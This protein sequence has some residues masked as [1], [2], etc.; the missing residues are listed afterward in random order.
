VL[1][2]EARR[3]LVTEHEE[4]TYCA[5]RY[6]FQVVGTRLPATSSD[7]QPSAQQLTRLVDAIRRSGA[8]AIFLESGSNPKLALE[9]TQE[10]GVKVVTGLYTHSLT[11]P[12]G[13]APDYLRMM[14]T[15]M[16]AIVDALR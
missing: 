9:I 14:E 16:R 3:L 15:N 8:P 4:F 5:R 6:G 2:P 11:P 1:I 10:A 12:G 13:P 7:A